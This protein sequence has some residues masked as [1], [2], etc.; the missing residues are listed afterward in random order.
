MTSRERVLTALNHEEPDR[1][2]IDLGSTANTGM[3]IKAYEALKQYLGYHRE[4]VMLSKA[5]QLAIMDEDILNL[6]HVDTRGVFIGAPDSGSDINLGDTQYEDEWGVVRH[7]P[8]SSFYYDVIGSPFQDESDKKNFDRFRWPDPRDP[9]RT[10]GMKER[11]NDCL[12]S[13]DCAVVLHLAGGFITQS[14]YL[15]GFAG[16]FED[17]LLDTDFLC[18]LLDRTL[19]FAIELTRSVLSIVGRD[20]DVIHFGDDLGAQNGLMISPACYRQYIKPRQAK[21][22]AVAKSMT[23]AKLLYHTCGSVYEIL[24]DLVEIGIDALNPIQHNARG[25]DCAMLKREY[26]DRL[27]FWGGIDTNYALPR[28][29]VADV[30][31]EVKKRI[32]LLAPGGGYILNPVHNVQPDVP[33]ENLMAMIEACRAYGQYPV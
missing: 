21:L 12:K 28:G 1:V 9:G 5:L 13:S 2:P 3:T 15:R 27:A 19:D 30:H 25:M 26:G 16:W 10:R 23:H 33:P 24:D 7:K 31:A 22:F 8:E 11:V 32:Q 29:S 4:T 17:T 6:L 18:A 20:V 14:Q